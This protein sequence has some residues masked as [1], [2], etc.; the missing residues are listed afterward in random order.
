MENQ[1]NQFSLLKDEKMTVK[2]DKVEFTRS[3]NV[4]DFNKGIDDQIARL[5]KQITALEAKK[6][7]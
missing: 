1:L 3:V 4:S 5:Q 7:K 6:V 2:G